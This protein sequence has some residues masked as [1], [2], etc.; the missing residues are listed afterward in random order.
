M[1]CTVALC[2]GGFSRGSRGIRWPG[3]RSPRPRARRSA[4][5]R[6]RAVPHAERK[7]KCLQNS[8]AP[9]SG[10]WER[11]LNILTR[12]SVLST[13][14]SV[15]N[16]QPQ[17][18]RCLGAPLKLECCRNAMLI[19]S[20]QTYLERHSLFKPNR[21]R[22]EFKRFQFQRNGKACWTPLCPK[23]IVTTPLQI[24]TCV[25][26]CDRL[27]VFISSP[28]IPVYESNETAKQY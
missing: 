2:C 1:R 22:I 20:T 13:A 21:N 27:I 23:K 16:F 25:H 15:A 7:F 5:L 26:M 19:F 12:V 14:T 8:N 9:L 17:W 3:Q 28:E 10:T 4:A 24:L 6:G 11:P 18:G